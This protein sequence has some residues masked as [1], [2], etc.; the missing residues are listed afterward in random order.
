MTKS[1]A[2]L[3]AFFQLIDELS[4]QKPKPQPTETVRPALLN[5]SFWFILATQGVMLYATHSQVAGEQFELLFFIAMVLNLMALVTNLTYD[6]I[7]LHIYRVSVTPSPGAKV[8]KLRQIQLQH[9][10]PHV[11]PKP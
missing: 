5:P 1:Q 3:N 7:I 10:S 4:V 6:K 11:Q 8:S 9:V 2:E